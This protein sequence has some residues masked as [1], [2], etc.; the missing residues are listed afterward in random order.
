MIEAPESRFVDAR[1]VRIHY[2]ERGSGPPL[3]YLHGAGGSGPWRSFQ[4][5]LARRFRLISPDHP[6]FGLSDR[7]D[8]LGEIADVVYHYLDLLPALG[9]GR[10]H[11]AGHSLGAWIAAE[12]TV[13]H[14]EVVDRLVLVD[15][16]G[17]RNADVPMPD[18]FALDEEESTRI[19]F[20]DQALADSQVAPLTPQ[21]RLVWIKNRATFARLSWNPYLYNPRLAHRLYRII[22]PT[23]IVW[24]RQDRVIPIEN[25]ELWTAGIPHAR[26]DVVEE[27]GHSPPRERPDEFV[28][29]VSD[30][31]LES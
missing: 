8:W 6:G 24:G 12:L 7:P 5:G 21:E 22:A 23:Q 4:E 27:C 17:L 14:P 2:R 28:R 13:A 25:A 15:P 1:G 16:A 20:H 29:L 30:F 11:V 19:L 10:V 9:L 3:V 18:L 31:L 26:L